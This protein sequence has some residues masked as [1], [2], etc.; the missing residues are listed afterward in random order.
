MERYAVV[1]L[2]DEATEALK[3]ERSGEREEALRRLNL[4]INRNAPYISAQENLK[5]QARSDRMKS[6]MTESD[7][8]QSQYDIY[9]QKRK[10][11]EKEE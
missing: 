8:K 9:Q 3:L 10:K 11:E 2:A 1:E 7:R 4:S 5:Y 6:G